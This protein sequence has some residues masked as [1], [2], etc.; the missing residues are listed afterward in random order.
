MRPAQV[1]GLALVIAAVGACTPTVA[2]PAAPTP[3]TKPTPVA[4]PPASEP[5]PARVISP[6]ANEVAP[7]P[8]PI[9]TPADP[10]PAPT[11]VV[12][13]SVMPT[14]EPDREKQ[15][16]ALEQQIGE[17]QA[18]HAALMATAP[19]VGTPTPSTE[20]KKPEYPTQ[21][22]GKN[23]EGWLKET[24]SPDPA[25]REAA[26]RAV[27]VFGP[28]ARK[29]AI[30]DM[31]RLIT[32]EDSGVRMAALGT[33]GAMLFEDKAEQAQ[34]FTSLRLL[35][36]RTFNGAPGRLYATRALAAY[37]ADA[38]VQANIAQLDE[39]KTDSWWET[40]KAVA[41]ALGLIGAPVY[42]DPPKKDP[43]TGNFVPKRPASEQAQKTLRFMLEHD[44]SAAV[45]LEAANSLIL[46]G[47]PAFT[48]AADYLKAIHPSFDLATTRLT[49]KTV[50]GKK[51]AREDDRTVQVWL[52]VL[53]MMLDDRVIKD[54]MPKVAEYLQDQSLVVRAQTLNALASMGAQ[55][56]PVLPQ[57]R[58]CLKTYKDQPIL[59]AAVMRV[60][61][62]M[63]KNVA[64]GVVP[65]LEEFAKET[66]DEELKKLTLETIDAL[67]GKKKPADPK[68]AVKP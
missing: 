1:F 54:T 38:G 23:L 2:P 14:A 5:A 31:V 65:D 47:P 66:K 11:P 53:Q 19:Q 28:E 62:A 32:D 10:P 8:L 64:G 6:P 3:P 26:C 7:A 33:V 57:V 46:L 43:T 39:I 68:A 50:D 45:R 21:I 59:M 42:D 30:K 58:E 41:N 37:G 52:Y 49:G 9:T 67:S 29:P 12:V 60:L 35:L 4:Q 17:L 44:K 55:S 16:A 20:P 27:P 13:A 51:A 24:H 36:S 25:V 18:K 34:V 22:D 40:R 56:E 48:T 63:G 15:L 61:V